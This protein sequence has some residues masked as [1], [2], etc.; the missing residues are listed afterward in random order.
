MF[1]AVRTKLR[2][3]IRRRRLIGKIDELL[4]VIYAHKERFR[5]RPDQASRQLAAAGLMRCCALLR[6]VRLFEKSGLGVV[7]GVLERAHWETWLVSLHVL[8]G[9]E[10][11]LQKIGGD[12]IYW[13]R[14]LAKKFDLGAYHDDWKGKVEKLNVWKLSEDL[15]PLLVAAG[16]EGNPDGT[17]GYDITFRVQSLFAAHACLASFGHFIDYGEEEWKAVAHPPP[18]FPAPAPTPALHTAHLARYVF[19]AFGF[20]LESVERIGDELLALVKESHE[21]T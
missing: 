19:K 10:E 9:G 12:D 2:R 1:N 8:L 6:G 3:W 7:A 14:I 20:P 13:K 5:S 17:T 4:A 16:E 11:A 18:Q 15:R 21:K